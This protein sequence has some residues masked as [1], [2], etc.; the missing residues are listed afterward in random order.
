MSSYQEENDTLMW[1]FINRSFFEAWRNPEKE[2]LMNFRSLEI[3][4]NY[5]CNLACK[6]CYVNRH[7]EELYPKEL[8]EDKDKLLKNVEIILDFLVENKMKPKIELFSGE[9]LVQQVGL[10]ALEMIIDKMGNWSEIT[11]VI[12]TNMSW[13]LSDNLTA[14]IERLIAKGASL[15][16][17]VFLSGSV[18]GKYCEINRPFLAAVDEMTTSPMRIVDWTYKPEFVEPRGD[19]FYEKF[20]KLSKKYGYGFH[21]MIYS[22]NVEHWI[23]NFMWFQENLKKYEIPWSSIYLLEVRN[24]EWTEQQIK[25]F[26]KFIEFLI[27]FSWDKVGRN[28]ENY[29]KF[30]FQGRG[31]NILNS[32]ISTIG[33]G[34]GCS[35]QSCIY[36]RVGDMGLAPC[37]RSCY[38]PM[39]LGNFKVEDDKIVGVH[40][41]N[42]ELMIGGISA[43]GDNFPYCE[44][45]I[46]KSLCSHGCLGA[47]L[48]ATGDM[49]TPIPTMCQMEHEK[50]AAMVRAY[51]D[52]GIFS[53]VLD[54]VRPDKRYALELV[55]KIIGGEN[56]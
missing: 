49:F 23:K 6:Y 38:E 3:M 33:R 32:P 37:H 45:C 36:L 56:R 1:N 10:Q 25:D 47:Q 31:F 17:N 9:A 48:E 55:E 54:R 50:I 28:A 13:L 53:E 46:I 39:M 20:F 2:H 41:N 26:G 14:E 40:A 21:P 30:M 8:Y 27:Y 51:K 12:P 18:D 4:L 29:F 52:I 15:G 16:L 34:L 42:F 22:H 5:K 7:G 11:V 24:S 19:E 43:E 44:Q 35:Y